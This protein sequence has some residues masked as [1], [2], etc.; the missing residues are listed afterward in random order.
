M[1]EL[2]SKKSCHLIIDND[3]EDLWNYSYH[4]GDYGQD[5]G[6]RL[7]L[8]KKKYSRVYWFRAKVVAGMFLTFPTGWMIY[9][10]LERSLRWIEY[11]EIHIY[12]YGSLQMIASGKSLRVTANRR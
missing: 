9:R 2:T 7:C 5:V 1:E 3:C 12:R 4:R 8:D 11:C 10:S 6:N